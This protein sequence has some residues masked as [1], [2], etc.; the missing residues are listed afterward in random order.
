M[1]RS[2][3]WSH[4]RGAGT[5]PKPAPAEGGRA[6]RVQDVPRHRVHGT[7][8]IPVFGFLWHSPLR[9]EPQIGMGLLL[10]ALFL[11]GSEV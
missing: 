9:V 11:S 5:H 8:R 7:G 2:G 4:R 6:S 3:I 1:Y 10:F